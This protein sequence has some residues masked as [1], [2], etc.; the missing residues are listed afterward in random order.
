MKLQSFADLLERENGKYEQLM[1]RFVN[2]STSETESTS[3]IF[4][5]DYRMSE[6]VIKVIT[7]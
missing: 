6:N 2:Y 7:G 5:N 4:C 3:L 1:L